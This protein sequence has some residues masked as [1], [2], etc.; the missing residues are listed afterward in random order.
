[1]RVLVFGVTRNCF[2]DVLVVREGISRSLVNGGV[3]P[4]MTKEV[5]GGAVPCFGIDDSM[6]ECSVAMPVECDGLVSDGLVCRA[7]RDTRSKSP[8]G[9]AAL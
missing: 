9:S 2:V 8:S 7:R 5:V 4:T 6:P 3:K 1:M